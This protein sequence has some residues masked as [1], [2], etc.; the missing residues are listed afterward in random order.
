MA[1]G[2]TKRRGKTKILRPPFIWNGK[3]L[4]EDGRVKR[5]SRAQIRAMHS[6]TYD[7]SGHTE[8]IAV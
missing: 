5:W 4:G 2:V 6:G 3:M 1:E 8:R 7:W